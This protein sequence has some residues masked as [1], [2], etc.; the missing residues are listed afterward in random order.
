MNS[1]Q[2]GESLVS[3]RDRMEGHIS[4]LEGQRDLLSMRSEER[5]HKEKVTKD[6]AD[7]RA[8][9]VKHT[10]KVNA[11]KPDLEVK[12]A[13]RQRILLKSLQAEAIATIGQVQ[14]GALFLQKTHIGKKRGSPMI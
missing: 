13:T 2:L 5:K 12:A 6:R 11:E 3:Y 9:L 14:G 8:I 7:H 4:L 1:R 10:N